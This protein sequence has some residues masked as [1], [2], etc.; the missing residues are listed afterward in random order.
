MLSVTGL[1]TAVT[2]PTATDAADSADGVK[3]YTY[4]VGATEGDNTAVVSVPVVN[5]ANSAQSNVT[6]TYS[7]KSTSGAVS[8]ADV[9]KA[10]V[11][12][13]AS[14]NKQI[15]TLQRALLRR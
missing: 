2:A 14:I 13:I 4:I 9:L 7:I 11:S 12:L 8:N 3:K 6:L 15:A 5:S 10:I 1:G